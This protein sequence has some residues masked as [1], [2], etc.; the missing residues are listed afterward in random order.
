MA[1]KKNSKRIKELEK[2]VERLRSSIKEQARMSKR[3]MFYFMESTA[4][5]LSEVVGQLMEEYKK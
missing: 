2:E 1:I 4:E 5:E 3:S